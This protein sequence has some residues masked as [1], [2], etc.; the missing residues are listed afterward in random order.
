MANVVSNHCL[1]Q[2]LTKKIDFSADTFISILMV[3]GFVYNKDT[4]AT[5][6]DVSASELATGNGYTQNTK[7]L[8]NVVVE[9][10]DTNDRA[11][12]YWDDAQWTASGGSIGP[13]PCALI[14][15]TTTTD[16]T[17]VGCIDF[18]GNKTATDGGVFAVQ[19]ID[20]GVAGA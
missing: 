4:H 19:N 5:Y 6:A 3:S 9:E 17:V 12:A 20:F 8:A 16:D 14:I 1:Y 7:T 13:S 18:G 15:D 10:D 11:R 2:L